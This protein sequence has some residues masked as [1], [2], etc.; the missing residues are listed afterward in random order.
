MDAGAGEFPED[1]DEKDAIKGRSRRVC[2]HV[3]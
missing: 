1:L 3:I 2:G